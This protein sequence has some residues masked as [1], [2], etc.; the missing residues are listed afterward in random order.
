MPTICHAC[1][2][3]SNACAIPMSPPADC[4]RTKIV[5]AL[6]SVDGVEAEDITDTHIEC[7]EAVLDAFATPST[8]S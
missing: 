1:G 5:N 6:L 8:G 4:R 2:R 3:T 7:A